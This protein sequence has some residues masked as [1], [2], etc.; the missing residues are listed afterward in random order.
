MLHHG[1]I[2]EQR[3][4]DLKGGALYESGYSQHGGEFMSGIMK[5]RGLQCQL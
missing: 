2:V 1:K 5:I 3:L 4:Y